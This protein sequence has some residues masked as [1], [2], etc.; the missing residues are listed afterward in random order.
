MIR[1]RG[2]NGSDAEIIISQVIQSIGGGIASTVTQVLRITWT[3]WI[4][5]AQLLFIYA[6]GR[7]SGI[8]PSFRSCYGYCDC[9]VVDR[10]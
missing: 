1:S 4:G 5:G 7:R 8:C 10:N 2:A 9:P 6:S 3:F